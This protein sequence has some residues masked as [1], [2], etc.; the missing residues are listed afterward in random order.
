MLLDCLEAKKLVMNTVGGE[1]KIKDAADEALKKIEEEAKK[2][3]DE[4]A[5]KKSEKPAEPP[6]K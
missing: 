1:F 4:E 2:K 3:K 5:K 6:K